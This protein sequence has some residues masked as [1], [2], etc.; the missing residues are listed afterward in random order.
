M[1]F[2][3]PACDRKSEPAAAARLRPGGAG[4]VEAVEDALEVLGGEAR[5]NDTTAVAAGRRPPRPWAEPASSVDAVWGDR[6]TVRDTEP[7]PR[8][9]APEEDDL[10][11]D[12]E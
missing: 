3:E 4:A 7:E 1:E 9:D 8:D 10:D 6:K 5:A 12:H 2:D 11:D